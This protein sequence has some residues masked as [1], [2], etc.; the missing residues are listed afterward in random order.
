MFAGLFGKLAL[1]M[2]WGRVK[3]NAAHDW[4][5]IPPKWRKI[6][7]IVIA[8]IAAFFLHQWYAHRVIASA[9]AA[10]DK[11]GYARARSEDAAALA[12]LRARAALATAHGA[13]IAQDTRSKNDAENVDIHAAAHAIGVRGPG[14]SSCRRIGDPALSAAGGQP[15]A[16][17]NQLADAAAGGVP[18]A[19]GQPDL[20]AVPFDWL[21]GRAEQADIDRAE[22]LSWRNWYERQAAEW[23][24]LRGAQPPSK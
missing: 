7:L 6:L 21:V 13:A 5:A 14:A 24:K 11:A 8:C 12:Q 16:S 23:E 17:G 20:A 9:T 3:G 18:A 10:G 1:G 4:Q 22:V 2:L 15:G 19:D